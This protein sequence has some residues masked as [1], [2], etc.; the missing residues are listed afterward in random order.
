MEFEEMLAKDLHRY[1][2][3][4]GCVDNVMPECQDLDNLWPS[5][6]EAYLPDGVREFAD[7]PLTSLGWIVFTGM[8]LAKMWDTDWTTHSL[9][10]GSDIYIMLRQQRGFDALD[11]YVLEEVLS[12]NSEKSRAVATVVGEC[13]ARS[14]SAL[15]HSHFEAGTKEATEAYIA[16]LHALYRCGIAMG[17]NL[18]GYHMT[19]IG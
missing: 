6:A 7:Y 19:A 9:R 14:Q 1:L 13:A 4:Q 17:L 10:S 3:S 15:Q 16:A 12:L 11:D 2:V 8:A 18:L 5:V